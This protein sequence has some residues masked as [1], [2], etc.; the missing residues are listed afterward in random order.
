MAFHVEDISL[1][2]AA[3]PGRLEG[4]AESCNI[5][6]FPDKEIYRCWSFKIIRIVAREIS[7]RYAIN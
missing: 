5:P 3:L 2:Y 4:R 7:E 1:K 6:T